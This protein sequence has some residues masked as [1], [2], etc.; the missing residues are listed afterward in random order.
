MADVADFPRGGASALTPL[1]ARKVRD[2][3][4]KDVLFGVRSYSLII[5]LVRRY[6]RSI[7]PS[8]STDL[9]LALIELFLTTYMQY[10]SINI[11][12]SYSFI[13]FTGNSLFS[14]G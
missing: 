4:E 1:E 3:A 8:L 2:A 7:L 11:C 5:T 9:F 13:L 12:K 6:M 10:R 14:Y